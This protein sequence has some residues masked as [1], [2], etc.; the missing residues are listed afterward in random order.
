MTQLR[1]W[2]MLVWLS[3]RRLLWSANSLMALVPLAACLL[4]LLKRRFGAMD[5]PNI[6]LIASAVHS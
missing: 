4:F 5:F 1:A 6:R 3:F 2:L